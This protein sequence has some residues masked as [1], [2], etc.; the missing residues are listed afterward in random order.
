MIQG[1]AEATPTHDRRDGFMSIVSKSP[2]I[3]VIMGDDC[4]YQRQKARSYM[5]SFLQ[6]GEHIDCVYAHND[7]MAIGARLAWDAANPTGPAP[8]FVGIDGCQTEV[9]DLI[10]AGKLDATF[11]YPTPGAKGIEVAAEILKGNMPKGKRIVLSTTRV[12]KENADD[13]AASNPNLAK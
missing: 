10:K 4:S 3:H 7:E 9:I 12:T 13:Y 5:E 8:I 6:K 2:G 1:I 11:Q